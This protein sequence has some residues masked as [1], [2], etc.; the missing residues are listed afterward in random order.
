LT[1]SRNVKPDATGAQ[2]HQH[3]FRNLKRHNAQRR[4][5]RYQPD[6]A[7]K[8]IPAKTRVAV[9]AG[10]ERVGQDHAVDPAMDD[11]VARA[12]RDSAALDDETGQRAWVRTSPAR[13]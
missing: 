4:R 1:A 13:G 11:A 3:R 12:Q 7:G 8:L 6:P 2:S 9:G 10:A 5:K